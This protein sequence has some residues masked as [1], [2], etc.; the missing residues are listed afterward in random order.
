MTRRIIKGT[1]GA[2][3]LLVVLVLAPVLYPDPLFAHAARHGA[4]DIRSDRPIDPAMAQVIADA[5]RRLRTSSLL[6]PDDRFRV[7]ICNEPWRLLL[8]ARSTQLGGAAEPVTRNIYLRE[9]DIRGNRLIGPD[10]EIADAEVRPLSYFI[11]HEAA[12]V[13]EGR[14]FGRLALVKAPKWL[15]DGLADMIGKGGDFDIAENRA[16][17]RRGDPE[18]SAE[19]ARV[20]LYRRYH[21]MVAALIEEQGRT[22]AELYAAPPPESVALA[23][24]L[25]E[26]GGEGRRPRPGE[27][28]RRTAD[29]P[30]PTANPR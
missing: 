25:G 16:R 14:R 1:L 19:R 3:A 21:L 28:A 2:V 9:A 5:E 24:A 27:G 7:Y 17:L 6:Q 11:A 22:P 13:L 30:A 12:H 26:G 29:R 8:L 4:F 15:S 18:M 23:A 20:G 10:G